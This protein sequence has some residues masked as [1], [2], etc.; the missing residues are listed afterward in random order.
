MQLWVDLLTVAL[1]GST[2]WLIAVRYVVS[3]VKWLSFQ[4]FVLALFTAALAF[5]THRVELYWIALLTLVVKAGVIPG[6]LYLTLQKVGPRR[7][8]QIAA[9]RDKLILGVLAMWLVG[10]YVTPVTTALGGNH[11]FLSVAIG[12]LL[13]GV[14]V[15][16]THQKAMMQGI[17][18]IVIENG[19]FL[20]ALST[21]LGMP[22]LVD[23]G[24][25]VD[26][27]VVVILIALLTLRMDEQFSSMHIEKLRR[28][29]G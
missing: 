26:V 21:S 27:L 18:L 15:M 25:F 12:M 5:Q 23:I 16:I 10:Y 17:G 9:S 20:A 7:Q 2:S 4:S 14:L 6:I 28:L 1:I 8:A 24:I 22:L 13:S 19:L 11:I 3:A 29:R